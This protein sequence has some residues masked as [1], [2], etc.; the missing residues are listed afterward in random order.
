MRLRL[1]FAVA[2]SAAAQ[3]PDRQAL[4]QIRAASL[5]GHVS[6]L[7]SDLLEGR[8]TPSRG[9]DIAAEYIAAQFRRAGLAPAGDDGF[10]Q[11]ANW[12]VVEPNLD[13]FAFT[14]DLSG[15][16]VDI[17]ASS[18]RIQGPIEVDL[19]RVEASKLTPSGP[20]PE[21]IPASLVDGKVVFVEPGPGDEGRW[22]RAVNRRLRSL[23]PALVVSISDAPV[24]PVLVNPEARRTAQGPRIV[25]S[26]MPE[27][28]EL[29]P[30]PLDA[31]VSVRLSPPT[32]RPVRLHNVAGVLRGSDA[33]LS[34]QFVLVSA[35]YDHLGASPQ[36]DADSIYNGANDDASGTAALIELAS[37]I[38]GA[39]HRPRRSI[40]FAAFFGEERGFLGSRYYTQHPL[41]PLE[42]TVANVNLEH[43]GRTDDPEGPKHDSA[44]LTGFDFSDVGETLGRAAEPWGV[45]IYGDE[46]F[47]DAYFRRSDNLALAQAGVPAHT[48]CVAFDFPDYHR[49]GDHW[50]KLDYANM[51]KVVRAVGAGVL[52]LANAEAAPKWNE[53]NSKASA[54][55]EAWRKHHRAGAE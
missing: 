7:A 35:H 28:A 43:L 32:E 26:S 44:N 41:F 23:A 27:I 51:E 40:V 14:V 33:A 36:A 12:L 6:F 45:R 20:R 13:G 18:V 39:S 2:L 46:K 52:S 31:R 9:L 4:E 11:T 38:A 53:K 55:V 5:S 15:K 3:A 29:P 34:G 16:V 21:E 47:G 49:T 30:G 1:L 8:A 42:K 54:Y 50:D 25:I 22:S 48:L 17:P 24:L 19:H 10:Y 37:A